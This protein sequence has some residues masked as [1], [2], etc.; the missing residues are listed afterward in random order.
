MFS[1]IT[2][3]LKQ[4]TKSLVS[5]LK[6]SP[7]ILKS[8][9]SLGFRDHDLPL[10]K[11]E[12]SRFLMLL[13]ALM[14]F[15]SVLACSGTFA[16]NN[17][18][19]RWSSG[20]ENKL[21]I[22]IAVETKEGHLLSN[23]T[24]RKETQKISKSLK[25]NP[26]IKSMSVLTNSEIQELISPWIGD[27]LT[28]NDIPLPGLI[29]IELHR[30]DAKSLNTLRSDI[31][32]IS[33]YAYIETHHEWLSDLINFAKTLKLLSI[34]ITLTIVGVTVI[35]I[36]AGVRTRLAIHKKEIL[37]LHAIGATDHYIARQFQ[38]HAMVLSLKGGVIGTVIGFLTTIVIIVS[39][40]HSDTTLI[41]AIEIS[42][43]G[44]LAL[45]SIPIMASIIATIASRFTV[46]RNLSKIP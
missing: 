15:L 46:L 18:T 33:K 17:M 29:A 22:E 36:T 1:K 40:R 30:A 24:V 38:R 14:S 44:I 16:L 42:I 11:S 34:F 26:L 10:D 35:A 23:N 45:C 39:S 32:K 5:S 3:N 27:N 12:D 9:E 43:I 28:L 25:G 6:H 8:R 7:L 31:K 21:T 2:N 19:H 20:L 13:I 4:S 41:P 37:L